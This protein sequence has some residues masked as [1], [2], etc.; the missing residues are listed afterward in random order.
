MTPHKLVHIVSLVD[1]HYALRTTYYALLTTYYA[2]LT[3]RYALLTKE[4][5]QW[6]NS[7]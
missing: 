1:I 6:P 5:P 3:T 4:P 7:S 2:L